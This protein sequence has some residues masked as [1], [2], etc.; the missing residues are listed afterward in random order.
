[1]VRSLSLPPMSLIDLGRASALAAD[2]SMQLAAT[3][4][5]VYVCGASR[6]QFAG[7]D[8]THVA[9]ERRVHYSPTYLFF[10]GPLPQ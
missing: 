4:D 1:M 3:G 2:P 8:A 5:Q 10:R 7:C 6:S 9:D